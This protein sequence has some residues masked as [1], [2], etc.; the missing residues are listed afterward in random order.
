[1]SRQ[2]LRTGILIAKP[3]AKTGLRWCARQLTFVSPLP[4]LAH[5]SLSKRVASGV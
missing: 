2:R 3:L 1:M 5:R 4:K